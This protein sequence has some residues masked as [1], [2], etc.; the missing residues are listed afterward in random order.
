M[1]GGNAQKS[2]M[3]RAKNLAN[4]A[5]DGKGGGGATGMKSRAADSG[6]HAEAAAMRNKL[7][8]DREEKNRKKSEME[9]AAAKRAAKLALGDGAS[10]LTGDDAATKKKKAALAAAAMAAGAAPKKEKEKKTYAKT[11][12]TAASVD[13]ESDSNKGDADELS[14]A[15]S[16]AA[17]LEEKKMRE[18]HDVEIPERPPLSEEELAEVRKSIAAREKVS[19]AFAATEASA[20]AVAIEEASVAKAREVI[21]S[22]GATWKVSADD[23]ERM[24]CAARSSSAK[25]P[26]A[27]AAATAS[28]LAELTGD[29][30]AAALLVR[31]L[32]PDTKVLR[33]Q[34]LA[35]AGEVVKAAVAAGQGSALFTKL[36]AVLDSLPAD[37]GA[38]ERVTIGVLSSIGKLAG[39]VDKAAV[40]GL[41]ER[42]KAVF[43]GDSLDAAA[44][45][46]LAVGTHMR[47]A[48]AKGTMSAEDSTTLLTSA[49]A[50]MVSANS[51]SEARVAA[52]G[53]GAAVNALGAGAIVSHGVMDKINDTMDA[54]SKTAANCREAATLAVCMLCRAMLFK[55]EPYAI[56]LLPK[57]VKMLGDKEKRVADAATYAARAMLEGLATL[58]VKSV[59]GALYEGLAVVG[60]GGR[61]R[62]ECLQLASVLATRAPGTMGPCLPACIPLVL[63]C[64]NDSNAK[65]QAAA[66]EALPVLCSCVQ[67]AE[68][69]ST[70]KEFILLALRKPDTTLECIEEVLMTTFCNPMD[71]TSLAFMMPIIIR[72]IKDAN[73][74]LV[75]KAT[76]CAS[77]LCAL[78]KESSD[79]APFVPLLMPLLEN[80]KDH[81]SPVI[82]DVTA[83]ATA[84]LLE[85]AGDLIDG[86][87]RHKALADNVRYHI[88]MYTY[89]LCMCVNIYIYIYIYINI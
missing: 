37:A 31:A 25:K 65:V 10:A 21:A 69:A 56:P 43:T 38:A 14:E 33:A 52:C 82:R 44:A 64:I 75:K 81:S 5:A 18:H 26:D 41:L 20:K 42:C 4:A 59:V 60:G 85:G 72:G 86:A 8:L 87:K 17:E 73:Y 66:E 83:K 46:S 30:P 1:G 49:L 61:V 53:V 16:A 32:V 22:K 80:N 19:R 79:I 71:G 68:V 27:A 2:A 29:K 28:L 45:A 12:S 50:A 3:A 40:L 7:T 11:G 88:Y 24:L 63:E 6:V 58:S 76:V 47:V 84:A 78:V 67:N 77:N 57:L 51:V 74:D 35:A 54:K 70:L 15:E 62:I 48:I 34:A 36:E 13:G 39:S 89:I 55:F 9:A 23:F